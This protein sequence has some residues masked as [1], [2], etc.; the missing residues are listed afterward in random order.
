MAAGFSGCTGTDKLTAIIND[1]SIKGVFVCATPS[2]HAAI[3]RE[4]LLG[5]K[6]VFVEKPPCA[7]LQELQSLI[8]LQGQ[9]YCMPGLQKRFSAINQLLEPH[10][11]KTTTYNYRYLT[12]SYPE[13]DAVFELFIHPVDNCIQLFGEIESVSISTNLKTNIT[14]FLSVQHKNGI[15]GMIHLSTDHS[16]QFPVDE[17]EINTHAAV[18]QAA[19]PNKL[20]SLEKSH[21]LLNIP[22]EKIFQTP[23]VKKVHLDYTGFTP[24]ASKNNIALQGF[25]GEIVHFIKSVEQNKFMERHSLHSLIPTYELLEK[26]KTHL[27]NKQ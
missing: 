7:S 23:A 20:I 12:G 27:G 5:G 17:L 3:T 24:V 2:Q 6:H 18:F 25:S 15:T 10:R 13:G 11:L 22:F 21:R 19:Y 9:Q 8:K 16:W 1:P 14:C 26:I 4:L